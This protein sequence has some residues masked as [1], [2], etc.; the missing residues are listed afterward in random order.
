MLAPVGYTDLGRTSTDTGHSFRGAKEDAT[1]IAARY[2]MNRNFYGADP[3]AFS[4]SEQLITDHPWHS[5]KVPLSLDEAEVS[6]TLA[7]IAGG[8]FEIGDDLPTL[9]ADPERLALVENP[10]VLNMLR[11]QRAAVPEDLMTY[12]PEDGQPSIFFLREDRRQSILAVFNWTDGPRSHDLDL[13]QVG[14]VANGRI[15]AFDLFRHERSVTLAG[16]RLHIF[17]QAPHSVRLIKLVDG[18]VPASPPSVQAN[19]PPK[20]QIGESVEFKASVAPDSV[21]ALKYVWEFGD[22]TRDEGAVVHHAYTRNGNY[23]VRLVVD[24]LDGKQAIATGT[25]S[26]QGTIKTTFEVQNNRRYQEP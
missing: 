9:G 11:L 21:P 20:G 4:I 2:Y 25:F 10:D 18:S 14:F 22:G 13:K 24:G 6:I 3:D 15:E 16:G 26:A 8:M 23:N 19:I 5:Q 17:E 7:A 1:G 12:L